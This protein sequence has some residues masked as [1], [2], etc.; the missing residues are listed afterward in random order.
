MAIAVKPAVASE[1]FRKTETP[2]RLAKPTT[3]GVF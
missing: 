1:F 2:Q 3:L